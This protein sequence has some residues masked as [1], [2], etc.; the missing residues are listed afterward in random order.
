MTQ[1]ARR[2]VG[3]EDKTSQRVPPEDASGWHR[4]LPEALPEPTVWPAVVAFGTCLLAWGVAT[5]WVIS[6]LGLAA[7]AAGIGGWIARMRHEQTGK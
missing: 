1:K 3:L 6:G 7:F 5:S 4:P 2:G